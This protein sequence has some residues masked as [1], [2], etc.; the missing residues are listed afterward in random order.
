MKVSAD[1]NRTRGGVAGLSVRAGSVVVVVVDAGGGSAVREARRFD[2]ADAAGLRAFLKAQNVQRVARVVP[3]SVCVCRAEPAPGLPEADLP[4]SLSLM[5]EGLLPDDLPP[6]RKAWGLIDTASGRV[7]LL[8]A[9]RGEAPGPQPRDLGIPETWIA[10][11]AALSLIASGG[12]GVSYDAAT[13]SL[14]VAAFGPERGV[15]RATLA[16]DAG[17]VRSAVESTCRMVGVEPPAVSG[18]GLSGVGVPGALR[19]RDTAW[20][21]E[22]GLSVGAALALSA[23]RAMVRSLATM[24]SDGRDARPSVAA[25][26]AGW[27]TDRKRAG[28]TLAAAAAFVVVAPLGFASARLAILN[29][30]TRSIDESAESR[31]SAARR[32]VVYREMS[33]SRLPVTKIW[34][35]LSAA[36][37]VGV[38]VDSLSMT[39]EPEF[40]VGVTG[41]SESFDVLNTFA[42]NLNRTG[43]FES[44]AVNRSDSTSDGVTFDLS[45]RV[46]SPTVTSRAI[47][48]FAAKPLVNR[49]YGEGAASRFASTPAASEP[50]RASTP[51]VADEDD[52][53][54]RAS[55]RRETV[56]R[57]AAPVP[58]A[59]GGDPLAELSDEQIASMTKEQATVARGARR[60]A[61]YRPSIDAAVKSRLEAEVRKLE[62]R[63]KSLEGGS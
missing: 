41:T 55:A 50:A 49:L 34:A 15:V 52:T 27:L 7:A 35:D 5:A 2:A 45:A 31:A 11:P 40:R 46:A 62:E 42:A 18:T 12:A 4:Q 57:A 1:T 43:L 53:S 30:K 14:C 48:D 33:Q 59:R 26:A 39:A 32:A 58:S 9:W 25:R 38:V 51:V 10:E 3:G 23:D 63:L 16:S 24:S 47:D 37:P 36:T 19:G 61:L 8:T 54:S 20:V 22:Y 17:A 56:P 44:V 13:R 21:A 28:W 29:A 60:G 6:N